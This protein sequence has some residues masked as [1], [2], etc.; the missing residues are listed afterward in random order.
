MISATNRLRSSMEFSHTVRQGLRAGRPTVVV[1]VWRRDD[2]R[3]GV[4]P[5]ARVGFAVSK[6]VGGAVGRNR[7]KRR[8]R[9]LARPLVMAMPEGYSVVVRALPEAAAQPGRLATDLRDAWEAA[10]RK[11]GV[12]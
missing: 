3:P 12:A 10:C 9:A 11:E 6:A 2:P 8:L 4:P 1:H 5:S 7:V